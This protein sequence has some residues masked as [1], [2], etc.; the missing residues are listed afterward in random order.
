MSLA[1]EDI[2]GIPDAFAGLAMAGRT[3]AWL[4]ASAARAHGVGWDPQRLAR[5]EGSYL[6]HLAREL[7]RPGPRKG[8]MPG[9]GPLLDALSARDDVHLALLTGNYHA[10]A[11]IKLEYFNLWRYFRCGAFG[12]TVVDR[13]HLL[14]DAISQV[15]ASGVSVVSASRVVV[16]GDTPLDVACAAAGGARSIAV[17]TGSHGV[18]E[19]MAA[20]ADAVFRTLADTGAVLRTIARL[21]CQSGP[22]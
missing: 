20:G 9:I 13:N 1:F 10:G 5:F 16:I 4:L 19:L 12:D 21:S 22:G 2:F 11:R 6:G 15:R 17:A 7:Q 14:P 8:I 18:E 3:D